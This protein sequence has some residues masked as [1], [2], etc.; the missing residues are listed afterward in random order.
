MVRSILVFIFVLALLNCC[1]EAFRF[2]LAFFSENGRYESN[3]IR[4]WGTFVSISIVISIIYY[5][6]A[7]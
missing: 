1:R 7:Y 3:E 6:I 5:F 4:T 2:F